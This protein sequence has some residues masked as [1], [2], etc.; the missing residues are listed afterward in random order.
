MD[1][2]EIVE[3]VPAD[4]RGAQSEAYRAGW[5]AA[6][7]WTD[8]GEAFYG[9]SLGLQFLEAFRRGFN[10]RSRSLDRPAES[11]NANKAA[12]RELKDAGR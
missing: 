10:D 9:S 1:D 11:A 6:P 3:I 8:L 7:E 2:A 5:A 12:R 4:I